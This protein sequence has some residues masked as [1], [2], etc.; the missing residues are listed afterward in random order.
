MKKVGEPFFKKIVWIGLVSVIAITV[1]FAI[2]IKD[3]Q[4]DYDFEKFFPAEDEELTFFQEHRKKFES[5]NDFLLVSIE[6]SQGIFDSVFLSKVHQLSTEI[7][8]KSP[9]VQYV[10][11]ITN[12]KE[13]FLFSGGA[14]DTKPY[15]DFNN[16]DF[17]RDSI[18]IY[19]KKELINL[20]V[21]GDAKSICLYIRHDDYL[22]KK[23]SDQF[24]NDVQKR[25]DKYNF[26][27]V[28]IAGRTVGQK[29]YI[30]IMMKEM[31]FF[32]A[33]SIIMIMLFLWFAF[34]SGWGLIIPQLVIIFSTIWVVGLMG[35]LKEPMNI[36]LTTLP[37]I[38]FVVAM[39]DVIH[40]VSRYLDALRFK[41]TKFEAIKITIKEVGFATFLTSIT[42]AVGFY[43]LYF[44]N[45]QPVKIFGIIMGTGVLIAFLLTFI[46]LPILIYISPSPK[47]IYSKKQESFWHKHLKRWF[48]LILR[49]KARFI[50]LYLIVI[51]IS[52]IGLFRVSTNNFLMDDLSSKVPIKQDFNYLDKH[53]GGV[54]PFEL[55]VIIKDSNLTVWDQE[56]LEEVNK[57][58]D[59]LTDV[60][61]VTIKM[62]LVN[63]FKILN[64]SANLNKVNYYTLPES[65]RDLKKFRRLIK[66]FEGG[67][68]ANSIIDSTQRVMRISGMIP[69]WGNIEVSKKNE[70]FEKYLKTLES[71][72]TVNF[73]I[74]G[75][76]HLFDKNIRYLSVSL[77]KGLSISILLI[78]LI[79]G[80]VY[81]SFSI[82]LISV[83]SNV[84]PLLVIAAI[85][86]YFGIELKTSTAIIFTI[87]F[88][89]AVDDTIHYLGKFKYELNMGR[90]KVQALRKAYLTTGK[91]MILTTLIL[92]S[93]F[94]LLVFSSFMGT[95]FMGLM[96]SITLLV[97]LFTDLTLLPI[98]IFLFYKPKK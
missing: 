3:L 35:W 9:H 98:L 10:S 64:R 2:G 60:Y 34:R 97:A 72:N 83:V 26:E 28:H 79:M 1:F 48:L 90:S 50:I 39:S 91:A 73:K 5:E 46:L 81:R 85:M 80:F 96:M 57:V 43:T 18:R 11:S 32:I 94:L 70:A 27:D 54:R 93:G 23:K 84:I 95:F 36:L 69:D 40:V 68:F 4:F 20:L 89:I 59:Y 14:S 22:S 47:Y 66:M 37:T 55:A 63:T 13:L 53:Y 31:M 77:V 82:M 67:K 52:V 33:L 7:Q 87:A 65:S 41:Y 19:T 51:V 74:T 12:Q 8:N 6:R 38:M 30:D 16:L 21:A 45:V 29:F 15:I 17:K 42:T 71:N 56:V 61:G 92:C 44:V 24:I 88:G 58:E 78:A 25:I 75:T 49:R 62:S 76:A 86:G